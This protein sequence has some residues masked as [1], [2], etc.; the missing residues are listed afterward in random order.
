MKNI[1]QRE[2][3]YAGRWNPDE[4]VTEIPETSQEHREVALELLRSAR[5]NPDATERIAAAQVH[6]WLALS[7]PDADGASAALADKLS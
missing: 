7:A 2:P 1:P 5:G 6:A 4:R 3:G